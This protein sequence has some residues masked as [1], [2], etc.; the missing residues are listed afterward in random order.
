MV[1]QLEGAA[2]VAFGEHAGELVADALLRNLQDAGGLRL[3]GFEGAGVESEAEARGET[4]AAQ[5]AQLVFSE[6]ERRVADGA[7]QPGGEVVAAS[8]EVKDGACRCLVAGDL[9]W[10]EQQCR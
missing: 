8:D 6:A 1:E 9:R 5:H 10:V 2:G 3:H 4:D 7:D